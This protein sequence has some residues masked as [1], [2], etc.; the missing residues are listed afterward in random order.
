[1]LSLPGERGKG[2][3]GPWKRGCNPTV[4]QVSLDGH[5]RQERCRYRFAGRR[6]KGGV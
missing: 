4:C 5:G 2:V 1:L 3:A 6:V